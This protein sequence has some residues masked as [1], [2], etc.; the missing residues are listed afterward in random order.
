MS[1]AVVA[2]LLAAAPSVR[3]LAVDPAASV[4]RFHVNHK[5][6]A[7]DG[8]SSAI[9]GKALVDSDG[10]VRAMVRI[11]ASSFES[12][13]AN[14]DANM[15]ETLEVSRHPYV[16]LKAAGRID[17]G[18]TP[19]R[20]VEPTL[21]GE[22]DFHGVRRPVSVPVTVTFSDDGGARVTARLALSLD[23]YRIDRPSLL[24]VKLDDDCAVN[25]DLVLR[26]AR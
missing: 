6:H 12:G 13:D 3:S 7:V 14:R 4:V 9:E 8:R 20:P 16:V 18:A 21:A 25:V 11:P 5:L 15:R 2:L 26:A 23:S 24:F 17:P 19:G 10:A 22:L 1:A